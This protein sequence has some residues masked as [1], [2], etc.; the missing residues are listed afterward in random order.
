[1]AAESDSEHSFDFLT[2]A[3]AYQ[4]GQ[5][6]RGGFRVRVSA[7]LVKSNKLN[8]TGMRQTPYEPPS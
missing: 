8:L 4:S 1:M 7:D 6:E 2:E 5:L 3:R